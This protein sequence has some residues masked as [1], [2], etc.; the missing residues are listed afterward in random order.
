VSLV[1]SNLSRFRKKK[2]DCKAKKKKEATGLFLLQ[3]TRIRLGLSVFSVQSFSC[4][5]A[6]VNTPLLSKTKTKN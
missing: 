6:P 1:V 4:R 5:A 3:K 2:G